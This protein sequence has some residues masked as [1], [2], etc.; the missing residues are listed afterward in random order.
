MPHDV[1][2]FDTKNYNLLL[3]WIFLSKLELLLV[4]KKVQFKL[5]KVMGTIYMYY[6]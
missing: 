2:G 4:L 5:D 3:D 6:H 1:H